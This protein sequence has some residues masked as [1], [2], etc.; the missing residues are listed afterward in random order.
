YVDVVAVDEREGFVL[1]SNVEEERP[2]RDARPFGNRSRRRL[3]EA[4]CPEQMRGRGPDA[5]TSLFLLRF[6]A[7]ER[8]LVHGGIVGQGYPGLTRKL[9]V[10]IMSAVSFCL[11][12]L[13]SPE[14]THGHPRHRR[15]APPLRRRRRRGARALSPGRRGW[16]AW[17]VTAA[18]Y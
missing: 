9:T 12:A 14:S 7:R 3:F 11:S 13:S 4:V 2:R 1:V 16:P 5:A 8:G 17:V 15:R 18:P 6:T 10:L